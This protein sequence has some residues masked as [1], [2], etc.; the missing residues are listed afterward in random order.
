MRDSLYAYICG[1]AKAE[2]CHVIKVEGIED[3]IHILVKVKPSLAPSDFARIIKANSSKWIHEQYPNLKDF[4]WQS[5]FSC[6]S[7]SESVKNSLV[8]YIDKQEEH[9]KR[10]PFKQELKIFLEKHGIDFDQEHFL[11]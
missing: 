10:I 9:H 3:H 2:G 5:G 11:D 1:I 7:V 4:S 6:F 8:S